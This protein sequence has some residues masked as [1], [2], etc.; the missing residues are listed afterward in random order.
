MRPA[1]LEAIAAEIGGTKAQL[2][3]MEHNR[4]TLMQP[5]DEV[6]DEKDAKIRQAITLLTEVLDESPR[7]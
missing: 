6:A 3:M 4:K 2:A 7:D 1:I 5:D